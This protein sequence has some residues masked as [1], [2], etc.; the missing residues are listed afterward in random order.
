MIYLILKTNP[1]VMCSGEPA[2]YCRTVEDAVAW[3]QRKASV[4]TMKDRKFTYKGKDGAQG[5]PSL[6]VGL[7]GVCYRVREVQEM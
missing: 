2:G 7:G 5:L 1:G 6:Q 3:M 4:L